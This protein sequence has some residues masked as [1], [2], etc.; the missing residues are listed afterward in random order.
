MDY[1]C[2]RWIG[3]LALSFWVG[4]AM[5][6]DPPPDCELSAPEQGTVVEIVDGET[7]KLA[8]GGTVRLVGAKAPRPP[9]GTPEAEWRY[10]QETRDAVEALTK[11][12]SVSLR[13]GG[14]RKDRHGYLM[15]QVFVSG[16]GVEQPVWVQAELVRQGLARVYSLSDNAACT[17]AL[18]ML[19]DEARAARRGV[20]ASG[21][22]AVRDAAAV[23]RMR[24]LAG[25]YQLVEGR[26][27]EVADVRDWIFLNFDE[28]WREDF[29]VAIEKKQAKAFVEADLDLASLEGKRIRVRGWLEQRYGPSIKATHPEQIE[30]LE[31]IGGSE[32]AA[33]AGGR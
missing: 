33:E 8:D 10:S 25:T 31:E 11:G 17:G 28:D 2:K 22:Y 7:L 5:A 13:F 19:E 24:R 29:T 4:T 18:L 15:A 9:A 21:F 30:V 27:V 32:S 26:V 1:W 16:E 3:L 20:W 14:Q 6:A 23:D 12:K